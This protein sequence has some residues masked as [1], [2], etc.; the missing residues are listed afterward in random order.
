MTSSCQLEVSVNH[1]FLDGS[2]VGLAVFLEDAE[3]R[4]RYLYAPPAACLQPP[5]VCLSSVPEAK[6]HVLSAVEAKSRSIHDIVMPLPGFD[7]IYP[8]HHSKMNSTYETDVLFFKMS[9]CM[10]VCYK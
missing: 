9:L 3:I 4:T 10:L 6:A 5:D 2:L 8:T 1:A 7:V